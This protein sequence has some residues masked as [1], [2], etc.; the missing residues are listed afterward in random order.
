MCPLWQQPA[1]LPA[2]TAFA[3][4]MGGWWQIPGCAAGIEVVPRKKEMQG[5]YHRETGTRSLSSFVCLKNDC[6]CQLLF[7]QFCF[8]GI[9]V[10]LP[11]VWWGQGEPDAEESLGNRG[12][13][14]CVDSDHLTL[15]ANKENCN[16]EVKR[17]WYFFIMPV[18]TNKICNDLSVPVI[19]IQ[20]IQN[21][22]RAK[23]CR[24]AF[25]DPS[26]RPVLQ[27]SSSVVCIKLCIIRPLS[28]E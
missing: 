11:G 25:S 2:R 10:S 5:T 14:D 24:G 9:R 13:H 15:T 6:Y 19:T 3:R 22:A 28:F 8:V 20:H 4:W 21:Q 18:Y 16:S 27:G 7:F 26:S 1:S 12:E 17:P 23:L